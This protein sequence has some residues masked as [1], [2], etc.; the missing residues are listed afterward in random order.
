MM[1]LF[2]AIELG[3]NSVL[4]QQQVLHIIGHNIA[5]VNTEGYSRQ[6]VDLENIRPSVIGV[7]E[8][9][10]GVNILGV[11]S[12]RD[13]FINNQIIERKQYTGYYG[14]LS[15]LM[16]TV[17][18]LFDEAHGLGMSDGL[19]DFFNAWNDV[20]N[21]PTH[22]PT[23]DSLISR[24]Q[25]FSLAMRNNYQRL[26]D[27][28]EINDSNIAV[29]VDEINTIADEIAEL[30]EQ[31]AYAEGAGAPASDLLDQ[32]ERRIR[33]LSE[34]IGIN[35]YFEQANNSVTI[36]V[37]GQPLVSFNTVNHLSVQRNQYNSNYYDVY[38][39]QYGGLP[40]AN[41]TTLIET[42]EMGA[43]LHARDGEVVTGAG[44]VTGGGLVSGLRE[45]DF[46][47]AHGLSVGDLITVNGET[48]SVVTVTSSTQVLVNDFTNPVAAGSMWQQRD[49]YI[50]AYK[51]QL[52]KLAAGLI[53]NVNALHQQ[54]YTL[55]S[56]T[57]TN[58]N[59]FRMTTGTIA[60]TSVVGNT[61]N[62]G[63]DVS[64][65]LS[66]GDVIT[67][68]G[69]TRLITSVTPGGASSVTVN[70]PFTVGAGPW[71]Y[72]NIQG[73]AS[74]IEVDPNVEADSTLI[75]ASGQPTQ[76]APFAVGNNDI[77]LQIA[78][79]M[80]QN[81]PG[82]IDTD[83]DGQADPG[84]FHEYLHSFYSEIGNAGN[85][86]NNELDANGSMLNYLENRRDSISAVSLDEEAANLMQFE[87]SFQALGTFMGTIN[88][89][90]DVLMEIAR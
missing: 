62:F 18:S 39:D 38:I 9:G 66:V 12:I 73:A 25:S 82:V 33:D 89:M 48:R 60:V 70:S 68:G 57:T 22:I 28:Q 80:D 34:K 42:G 6:V 10:R 47:Q 87:K 53:S 65:T 21:Q 77:A 71:Q 30:N 50:P 17:E 69:E 35:F 67:I 76:T 54:G 85:T 7:K 61:V 78:Q 43:L 45:V 55:N 19:T 52:D 20:A 14:T 51:R 24:A 8:G 56:V 26:I 1:N 32:R 13:R 88:R 58:Q 36:E 59:F 72:A 86:A 83:N 4:T 64:T 90:L 46:S 2:S 40:A 5:N 74:Y 15:G 79:L 23:R 11:R 16:A 41:I 27:Q 75:A 63:G 37:A 31:I 49:G 81:N 29:L 84:T 3:K 44:T